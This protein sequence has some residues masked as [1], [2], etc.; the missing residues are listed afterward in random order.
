MYYLQYKYN[1]ERCAVKIN[2]KYKSKY[3]AQYNCVQVKE[4]QQHI[5]TRQKV[6]KQQKQF[7]CFCA[8]LRCSIICFVLFPL[9]LFCI[10][11]SLLFC[12]NSAL[13]HFLNRH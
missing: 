6:P 7:L 3:P 1:M 2:I 5:P 13:K 4:R 11:L 12:T 9:L 10:F 8:I